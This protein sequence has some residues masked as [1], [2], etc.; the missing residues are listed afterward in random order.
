[1]PMELIFTKPFRK[2][3]S[4]LSMRQRETVA[5]ALEQYQ[6]DRTN[7]A[8]QDHSLKGKMKDLRAFSAA[9]DLRIIYREE[10]G[11]ITILLLDAGT[12]NQVY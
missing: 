8:L 3:I 5:K 9:H 11:F 7:P 1:M 6:V 12:H 4:K 10:G 2:A